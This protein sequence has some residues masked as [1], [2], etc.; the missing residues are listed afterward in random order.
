MDFMLELSKNI[1]DIQIYV[2]SFQSLSAEYK[3][4]RI[5]YKEHPLNLAYLGVQEERDWIASDVVGYYP[6]FFAYWKK[7]KKHL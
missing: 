4:T 1:Q 6:S 5:Y 3:E 2:G 7:V